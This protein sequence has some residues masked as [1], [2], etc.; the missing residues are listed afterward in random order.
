[1]AAYLAWTAGVWLVLAI[2]TR[3]AIVFS[4][5]QL[6]MGVVAAS[7]VVGAVEGQSWYVAARYP[8]FDPWF[9]EALGIALALYCCL[10]TAIRGALIPFGSSSELETWHPLTT[11]SQLLRTDVIKIDRLLELIVLGLVALV[12][13][14]AITPGVGQELALSSSGQRVV[15]AASEFV[16]PNVAH[17]HATGWGAWLMLLATAVMVT[18]GVWRD[19]RTARVVALLLLGGMACYLLAAFWQSDVACASALR[20]A[21]GGYALL[22]SIPI[23]KRTWLQRLA[24]QAGMAVVEAGA[25]QPSIAIDRVAR[26]VIIAFILLTYAAMGAYVSLSALGRAGVPSGMADLLRGLTVVC[27]VTSIIALVIAGIERSTRRDDEHLAIRS[28]RVTLLWQ[29]LLMMGAAPLV[30]GCI[31]VIADALRQFPI[32]GPTPGSWF[33]SIGTSALY[34]AP[35]AALV[36]ALLGHAARERSPVYAFSSGLLVN[37]LATIV[38]L[39]ELARAGR[40]LGSSAWIELAQVNAIAA[41]LFSLG[42]L[43]AAA[44]WGRRPPAN[45]STAGALLRSYIAFGAALCG[46]TVGWGVVYLS[47]FPEAPGKVAAAGGWLGWTALALNALAVFVLLRRTGSQTNHLALATSCGVLVAMLA[48]TAVSWDRGNWLAYHALLAGLGLA[49]CVAPVSARAFAKTRCCDNKTRRAPLVVSLF[50]C[51]HSHALSACA[52]GRSTSALVDRRRFV[53]HVVA[54][55]RVGLGRGASELRLGVGRAA[56]PGG[57]HLVD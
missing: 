27:I 24:V 4:A 21:L 39:I 34:G 52:R 50:R 1:M 29:T 17:I 37:L 18:A 53:R 30:A 26:T 13:I 32:V 42:W 15:P 47:I 31:Y 48:L 28:R 2:E 41:A 49:A 55:G 36:A 22:A 45:E 46:V 19:Y 56:Q 57:K 40:P 7:V 25:R 14:Y 10:W 43:S 8:W 9:V 23:W 3:W 44:R 20:W 12:T 16:I 51:T 35:L 11:V 54:G 5:F 33:A 6:A 38:Y